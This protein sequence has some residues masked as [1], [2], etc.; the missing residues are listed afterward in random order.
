MRLER[1]GIGRVVRSPY[2]WLAVAAGL[3]LAAAAAAALASS[4]GHFPGVSR[5]MPKLC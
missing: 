3:V 5:E 4:R 1:P 2:F